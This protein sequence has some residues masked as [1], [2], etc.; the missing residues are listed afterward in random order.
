M[1]INPSYT[2]TP[3]AAAL[4]S[5]GVHT[6]AATNEFRWVLTGCQ[7]GKIHKWD[8]FESMNG[9]VPLTQAQKQPHVDSVTHVC[10]S[11]ISKSQ[12]TNAM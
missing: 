10:Q 12:I 5:A 8:F 3:Y 4:H 2:I 11:T 6:V 7:D 9:K 1:A